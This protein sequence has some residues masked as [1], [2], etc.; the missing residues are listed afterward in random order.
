MFTLPPTPEPDLDEPDDS[1][2]LLDSGRSYLEQLG[3]Y[4]A[5]RR[6]EDDANELS[7]ISYQHHGPVRPEEQPMSWE[8]NGI[9]RE[10]APEIQA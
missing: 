9:T 1:D 8:H 4:K 5:R 10:C 2:W 7:P 3:Y 6:A